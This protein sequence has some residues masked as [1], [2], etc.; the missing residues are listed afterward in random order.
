MGRTFSRN[1]EV[2][3]QPAKPGPME[4]DLYYRRVLKQCKNQY[5]ISV[6]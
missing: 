2:V 5:K 4:P 6:A 3:G 1:E